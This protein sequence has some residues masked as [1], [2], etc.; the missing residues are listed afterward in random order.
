MLSGAKRLLFLVEDKQKQIRRCDIV[1]R[2][3]LREFT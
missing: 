1:G 3:V 2:K